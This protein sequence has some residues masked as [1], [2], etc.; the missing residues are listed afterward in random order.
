MF[1]LF[2]YK[3]AT[4]RAMPCQNILTMWFKSYIYDESVNY[5]TTYYIQGDTIIHI[6]PL[7]LL[8]HNSHILHIPIMLKYHNARKNLDL[9]QKIIK[10][11]EFRYI[12]FI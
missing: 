5:N 9:T 8:N 12:F 1:F 3:L 2:E 11:A 10:L 4:L 6:Y 7:L